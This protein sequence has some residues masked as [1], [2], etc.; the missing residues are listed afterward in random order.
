MNWPWWIN[1][2]L[3]TKVLEYVLAMSF[4]QW[5]SKHPSQLNHLVK[6]HKSPKT[7]TNKGPETNFPEIFDDLFTLEKIPTTW[8]IF[9]DKWNWHV[10]LISKDI[11]NIKNVTKFTHLHE[12]I[13][14]AIVFLVC[15][16]LWALQL[17]RKAS[18][19]VNIQN[20][21]NQFNYKPFGGLCTSLYINEFASDMFEKWPSR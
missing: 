12:Q 10:S 5:N 11:C 21:W 14:F 3:T 8:Q 9:Y 20:Y 15:M 7:C 17:H 1:F 19:L 4:L 2:L 18:Q 6:Q 13:Q 16:G